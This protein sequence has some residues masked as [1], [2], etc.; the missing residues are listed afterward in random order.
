MS[1]YVGRPGRRPGL[2]S[3][4]CSDRDRGTA[5]SR[6][7][8]SAHSGS[9]APCRH[10]RVTPEHSRS[11]LHLEAAPSK[12]IN[13]CRGPAPVHSSQQPW[14]AAWLQ[15]AL[16]LSFSCAP[17][18]SC[19]L[20][21]RGEEEAPKTI[22]QWFPEPN[23]RQPGQSGPRKSLKWACGTGGLPQLAVRTYLGTHVYTTYHR[24]EHV[25]C[26]GQ[27]GSSTDRAAGTGGLRL[28]FTNTFGKN[29]KS[30][31]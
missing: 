25:L 24:T 2:R 19:P 4:S 14:R 5:F 27:G 21:S 31:E 11:H 23:L 22:S 30:Q 7:A 18:G 28:S 13:G 20:T 3:E 10:L 26:S 12:D 17:A 29:A 9:P 8:G 1:G 6:A 15:G 16:Q